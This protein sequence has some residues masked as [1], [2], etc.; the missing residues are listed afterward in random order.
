LKEEEEKLK[1]QNWKRSWSLLVVWTT[2]NSWQNVFA[3]SLG[4]MK[5][6]RV[7]KWF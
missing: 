2:K 3:T 7:W 1:Y 5:K 4:L 6:Q